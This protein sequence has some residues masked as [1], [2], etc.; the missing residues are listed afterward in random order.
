[1]RIDT[2]DEDDMD[3][4]DKKEKVKGKCYEGIIL[5]YFNSNTLIMNL[6]YF[7][8]ITMR[9]ERNKHSIP[10]IRDES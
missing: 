3:T 1:M 2:K 5:F 8:F 4:K 7:L 9:N 6:P 10:S